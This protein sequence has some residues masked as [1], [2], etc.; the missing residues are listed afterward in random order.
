MLGLD[1]DLQ[2]SLRFAAALGLGILLGL[3]REH[4]HPG[5]KTFG[6]VRTFA[7]VSLLG[8]TTAY[9]D[10]AIGLHWV[11]IA[12]FTAVAAF[13]LASYV[14]TAQRGDPGITTEVSALLAFLLGGLCIWGSVALA[15]ALTVA[16]LLLLAFKNWLHRLAERI[17][18]ADI[19][20][21]LKFAIITLI[22]LPLLPNESYGPAGLEVINPYKIWL[23]VVLI[24]GLNFAIYILVKV[25]GPE[26]S[27]GLTGLLGGL[28]SSTAVTLG[29]AQRSK[30]LAKHAPALALGILIAW[31][32]MFVRVAFEVAVVTPAL[33][34]A[35]VPRLAFPAGACLLS[36]ALLYRSSRDHQKGTVPAQVNP[37]E[38]GS[39]IRFGLL[40]GAINFAAKAAETYLGT[41]GLYLAGA[42]AGLTDVDAITLSMADLAARDPSAHSIASRTILIAAM[43][44]TLMKTG[45]VMALAAPPLRKTLL[46]HAALAVAAGAAAFAIR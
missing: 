25:M 12:G 6:G 35:V 40:F 34:P 3:E 24:S 5:D 39:A 43:S 26:H 10:R 15:G 32:V 46:P 16:S 42:L 38:L 33:T 17:E 21:T 22:V 41:A 31:A 14:I 29:F 1:L 23:M 8:A 30:Q 28:V 45:M 19:E 20:A 2:L 11:A 4:T 27:L 37:F 13:V 44:N 18:P 7:L 9:L 36:C